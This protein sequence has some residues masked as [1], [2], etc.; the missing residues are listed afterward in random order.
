MRKSV[1]VQPH[2]YVERNP[3]RQGPPPV[4]RDLP[5]WFAALLLLGPIIGVLLLSKGA[6]VFAVGVVQAAL[7]LVPEAAASVIVPPAQELPREWRWQPETV[8]FERMY[9]HTPPSPAA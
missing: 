6:L 5:R 1:S 9:R 7:P 4:I 3:G 2:P 8:E